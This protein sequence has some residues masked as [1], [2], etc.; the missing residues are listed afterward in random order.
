M[1]YVLDTMQEYEIEPMM[2]YIYKRNMQAW[3]RT[4]MES[5]IIAQVN[6]RKKITPND[7]VKFEWDKKDE[8][9]TGIKEI[10]NEDVERL[11]LKSNNFITNGK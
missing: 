11:K 1:E 7:I 6:S 4:R 9:F 5:Y 8:M 3:E 10:S 2:K